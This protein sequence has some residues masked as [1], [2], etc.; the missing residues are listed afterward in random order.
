MK[1]ET[2]D[3]IIKWYENGISVREFAPLL[4]QYCWLEIEAVIKE[5]K[6]KK[7]YECLTSGSRH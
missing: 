4:P 7:E 3:Q 5:Y 1:K 2:K 6:E